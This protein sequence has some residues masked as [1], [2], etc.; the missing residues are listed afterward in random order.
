MVAGWAAVRVCSSC[1]L[2]L[3]ME[4]CESITNHENSHAFIFLLPSLLINN[5]CNL[6]SKPSAPFNLD[7][8]SGATKRALF[9]YVELTE[10]GRQSVRRIM[11]I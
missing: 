2:P 7:G 8:D 4:V 6:R 11:C 9:F 3:F 10:E 5:G 1:I